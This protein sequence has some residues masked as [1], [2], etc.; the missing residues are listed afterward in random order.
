MKQNQNGNKWNKGNS[1]CKLTNSCEMSRNSKTCVKQRVYTGKS[2]CW[3]RQGETKWNMGGSFILLSQSKTTETI[4]VYR[5]TERLDWSKWNEPEFWDI[6]FMYH[7]PS[8][9]GSPDILVTNFC[10]DFF[11]RGKPLQVSHWER[12]KKQSSQ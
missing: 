9:N 7:N 11:R 10:S 3:L 5:R 1:K 6:L 2:L 4:G 8:S 12:R